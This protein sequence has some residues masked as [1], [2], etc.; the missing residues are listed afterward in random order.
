MSAVHQQRFW[1]SVALKHIAGLRAM[2]PR[3]VLSL[4]PYDF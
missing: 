3:E 2:G 1:T 4:G